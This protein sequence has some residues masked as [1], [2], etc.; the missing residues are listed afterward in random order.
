[1]IVHDFTDPVLG[2]DSV[3]TAVTSVQSAGC[4]ICKILKR[5]DETW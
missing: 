2:R 3:F 5:E 4:Q 1:M